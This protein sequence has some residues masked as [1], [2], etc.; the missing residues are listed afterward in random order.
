MH[1]LGDLF[2]ACPTD[3]FAKRGGHFMTDHLSSRDRSTAM[4]VRSSGVRGSGTPGAIWQ[5]A[6]SPGFLVLPLTLLVLPAS[7]GSSPGC[8]GAGTCSP[9]FI[10]GVLVLGV[11]VLGFSF[12]P[13]LTVSSPGA[14]RGPECSPG[15]SER[16]KRTGGDGLRAI[17][18]ASAGSLG[19]RSV[20]VCG[21]TRS[22]FVG[23]CVRSVLMGF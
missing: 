3:G 6:S 11:L 14:T 15:P 5:D 17:R 21:V 20:G 16:G 18:S 7:P 1:L 8:V 13:A 10:A 9:G 19:R 12:R 2:W 4:T 22:S 23:V